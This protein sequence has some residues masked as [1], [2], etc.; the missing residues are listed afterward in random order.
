MTDT[1]AAYTRPERK[2]DISIGEAKAT[3]NMSFGLLD[4]LLKE[5][6]VLSGDQEQIE[7]A[8]MSAEGRTKLLTACLKKRGPFGVGDY[9][10]DMAETI[11]PDTIIDISTWAVSHVLDFFVQ[12]GLR[13]E[14]ALAANPA[15][16]SLT[17]SPSGSGS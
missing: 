9:N 14:K 7:S 13:L 4:T 1:P 6:P 15:L 5:F 12:S 3:L 2:L 16:N 11:D 10:E 8:I 17:P